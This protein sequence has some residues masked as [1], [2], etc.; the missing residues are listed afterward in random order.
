MSTPIAVIGAGSWGT[1]L[2]IQL[3]RNDQKVLLWGK[4]ANELQQMQKTRSNEYYLPGI[5]FPENLVIADSLEQAL[6][7]ADDIL[8][9]VPSHAFRSILLEIKSTIGTPKRIAW[10]TKGL[11]PASHQ[12]LHHIVQEIFGDI[13][14]AVIAGPSFANEVA[15][16]LPTALTAAA[17]SQLFSQQ[18]KQRLHS[19]TFRVYTSDD[20]IGAEIGS[21]VKNVLAIAVGIADGLGLGANARSAIITR[22]LAEVLRLGKVL[23]AKQETLIGLA[24]VGDLVLTCTDNQSRN[25]RYGLALGQ[26]KTPVQALK[27]IGQVVEG[28]QTTK[29]IHHLAQQ[30]K[31]ELPICQQV[32]AVLH[33]GV[34]AIEAMHYLLEREP[35]AE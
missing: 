6:K 26:N 21:A 13:P 35:K 8:I 30:Y 22:G 20:I 17:T 29:E 28:I 11:D 24:G 7:N 25:R 18:L 3:A 5:S 23:G 4:N 12:L 1:A 10:A 34:S 27:E 16:G 2:A 19:K 9:V 14:V 31:V 33:Q 15:A 32:Y